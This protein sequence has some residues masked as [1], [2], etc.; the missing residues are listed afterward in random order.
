MEVLHSL[1]LR[2]MNCLESDA[3]TSNNSDVNKADAI[4]TVVVLPT[5]GFLLDLTCTECV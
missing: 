2:T 5:R 3:K 4:N 1:Y